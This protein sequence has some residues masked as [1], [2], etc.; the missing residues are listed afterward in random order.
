VDELAS[1]SDVTLVPIAGPEADQMIE[2]LGFFSSDTIPA[3]TYEGIGETT[4]LAVGAQWITSTA[5]DEELIY[6]I[7]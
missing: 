3:E 4:T 6:Q 1:S 5:Q 2:A 7:T